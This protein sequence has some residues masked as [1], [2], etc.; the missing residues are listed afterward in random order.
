[1]K[2]T[3]LAINYE[4]LGIL[5]PRRKETKTPPTRAKKSESY[6]Q[7]TQLLVKLKASPEDPCLFTSICNCS[8]IGR[9]HIYMHYPQKRKGGWFKSKSI[10]LITKQ[11]QINVYIDPIGVFEYYCILTFLRL[12]N[13]ALRQGKLIV[14]YYS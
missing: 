3:K 2:A 11:N 13:L 14:N 9:S 7:P 6:L 8:E 4:T 1:M 5:S 10:C 12:I